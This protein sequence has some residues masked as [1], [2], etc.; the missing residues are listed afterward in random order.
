[1]SLLLQSVV[2]KLIEVDIGGH[3]PIPLG[4]SPLSLSVFFHNL[5]FLVV[6]WVLNFQSSFEAPNGDS[7]PKLHPWEVETPIYPN[8]AH[9]FGASSPRVRILDVQNSPLF[10]HNK[11]ALKPDC[12]TVQRSVVTTSLLKDS[13]PVPQLIDF[14]YVC[15]RPSSLN[16]TLFR[17][18]HKPLLF[19]EICYQHPSLFPLCL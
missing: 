2:E 15:N 1:M 10:L 8:G 16:V 19:L 18:L 3:P 7:M 9:S 14:L 6:F 11:W 17:G 12:N 5:L 13:L 4:A